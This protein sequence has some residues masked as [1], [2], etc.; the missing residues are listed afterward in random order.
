MGGSSSRQAYW[1]IRKEKKKR[2]WE[3]GEGGT[4]FEIENGERGRREEKAYRIR[5]SGS[6][7]LV[8]ASC[9][10]FNPSIGLEAWY[11]GGGGGGREEEKVR[12]ICGMREGSATLPIAPLNII[13]PRTQEF[14]RPSH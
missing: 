10:I 4:N 2:G 1:G 6:V 14:H 12:G 7:E 11:E 8:D 3:V 5:S 9:S 13:L